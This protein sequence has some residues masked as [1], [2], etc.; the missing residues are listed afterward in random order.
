MTA[1]FPRTIIL[2]LALLAPACSVFEKDHSKK[3]ESGTVG[4]QGDQTYLAD[5]VLSLDTVPL[6]LTAPNQKERF[7]EFTVD[8]ES[9]DKIHAQFTFSAPEQTKLQLA[10]VGKLMENCHGV[11]PT[12]AFTW[13]KDD[14]SSSAPWTQSTPVTAEAGL[15]YRIDLDVD[16]SA[17]CSSIH[18]AFVVIRAY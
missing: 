7:N 14:A 16:N 5:A 15:T 9:K 13:K 12:P 3:T 8:T 17:G 11:T 10:Y 4:E 2:A 18:V 1:P 6:Q